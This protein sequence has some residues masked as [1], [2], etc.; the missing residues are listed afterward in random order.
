MFFLL[1]LSNFGW[2]A[3][4]PFDEGQKQVMAFLSHHWIKKYFSFWCKSNNFNRSMISKDLIRT[5][6]P[7]FYNIS[8]FSI[9][10]WSLH[11]QF[12]CLISLV[13]LLLS[14]L[15]WQIIV[16][17]W[18]PVSVLCIQGSPFIFT[19]KWML[20]MLL[21]LL[22]GLIICKLWWWQAMLLSSFNW[23]S[24]IIVTDNN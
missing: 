12:W 21:L 15:S 13:N 17:K 14:M 2:G 5:S 4:F 20:R 9:R 23:K 24:F 1:G 19:T 16:G 22:A 11:S 6:F 10:K 3:W 7:L 18:C 8:N